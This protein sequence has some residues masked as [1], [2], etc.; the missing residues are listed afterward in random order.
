MGS[1]PLSIPILGVGVCIALSGRADGRGRAREAEGAGGLR[2]ARE[3]KADG[4][5]RAREA[6]GAGG[7][8]GARD[9]KADGVGR[10]REAEGADGLEGCGERVARL[11][12]LSLQCIL[13]TRLS[14]EVL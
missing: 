5:A 4:V 9:E 12:S 14:R 6:E 3:E 11:G 7:L 10:A 1:I 8:G 2:G 13:R